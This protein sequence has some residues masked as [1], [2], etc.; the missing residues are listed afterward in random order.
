MATHGIKPYMQKQS[1]LT[2]YFGSDNVA[3]T[4]IKS[5]LNW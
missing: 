5:C 1:D 2:V 4:L 3:L